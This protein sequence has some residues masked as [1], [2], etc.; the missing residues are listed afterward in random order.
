[1]NKSVSPFW[2]AVR[3]GLFWSW[4]AIFLAF[5]LLGFAPRL[6]PEIIR[7][8]QSGLIPLNFLIYGIILTLVPVAAIILGLTVL[9]RSPERLFALGYVIEGPLMLLMVIRFFVIR[10][11]TPAFTT[12]M[13]VAGLGMAAF[14]WYL[15]DPDLQR[16]ERWN[17]LLKL[18]GLTLILMV[19]LYASVWIL[20]YTIPALAAVSKWL[21]YTLLHLGQFIKDFWYFFRDIFRQDWF[22]IPLTLLGIVIGFYTA[23]LFVL[24]PIAVP[25]L[26]IR[27]FLNSLKATSDQQGRLTARLTVLAAA[28]V[29]AVI[30]AVTSYQP[31]KQAFALLMTPPATVQQARDL[32]SKQDVIR[33]GLL[34]AYLAPYRYISSTGEVDHVT[35]LYM[36][37]LNLKRERAFQVQRVY[38]TVAFP[39]LYEPVKPRQAASAPNERMALQREPQ[40]AA[41]LYQRFFDQPI[42]IGEQETVTRAV[43]ATWS[44][45][46][47]AEAWQ[48]VADR[49]VHLEHQEINIQEHDGWAEVELYE[50]YHNITHERQEVLYYFNLP[51]SAVLTGVWLGTSPDRNQRFA[52]QIAP[53]GAAQQVYQEE[54][55]RRRDPALLEQI[56]PRQYR[57]RVFPIETDQVNW[58]V[59]Q[60]RSVTEKT[61]PV[62]LW[63]TYRTLP[64]DGRW[65]L[66]RLAHKTNLFWDQHTE[67][68]LNGE[69][70][71]PGEDA[72]MPAAP[73]ATA[74]SAVLR[75]DFP[76]GQSVIVRPAANQDLPRLPE[77]VRLA[78][79][80]DRSKSMEAHAGQVTEATARLRELAAGA[81]VDVYLTA[82]PYS[83]ETP[84]I[85]S[86]EQVEP[87]STF[88]LGGQNPA[89]LLAQFQ[90][91]QASREYDGILI[92]T[93]ASPYVL[94]DSELDIRI[95][96]APL[97][98]VHL[99]SSIPLGYD[100]KTLEAIQASGGGVAGDIDQAVTRL[101]LYLDSQQRAPDAGTYEDVLDGYIMR[102][103]PTAEA[104]TAAPGDVIH[105]EEDGLTA[106]LARQ[107]VLAEMRRS[108]GTITQLDTLDMLHALAKQYGI[109]TPYSS[110][111]VLVNAQQ[112]ERL[113]ELEQADDRFEREFEV[114]PPLV[115]V[116]EPEEWLLLSIMAALL[117]WYAYKNRAVWQ[118]R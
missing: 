52:Y 5:M 107:L 108:R 11:A 105:T 22:M 96:E 101:A 15:L 114:Q 94:G 36:D 24:T 63:M 79:V 85:V 28:A 87:Q 55:A 13:I 20:F 109:V 81:Q 71:N 33:A 41:A 65:P 74:T 91:L 48:A 8:V 77:N 67:R 16:R 97:W 90:S 84:V 14:L 17:N 80:I 39:F 88:Y 62:Y 113:E 82:S 111:I 118:H 44:G 27:A 51:E 78:V 31:Q 98:L 42:A 64:V 66:P 12:M 54:K 23:T 29:T 37:T 43:R 110:M 45:D 73:A 83:G 47:A 50:V 26:S 102:V 1:M 75:A 116:P 86:M 92:L 6:L 103:L 25:V 115:G 56:G 72:W 30:F 49:E 58:D 59:E 19:S 100:D 70:V 93:D 95:P 69:E 7:N 99:D 32:L 76:N 18:V 117:V 40:E 4:N 104:E 10:Q 34:N 53:R 68:L 35:S 106:L 61:F 9:R 38:E 89:E 46:Q 3:S 60:S 2:N 57:L 21:W 112:I